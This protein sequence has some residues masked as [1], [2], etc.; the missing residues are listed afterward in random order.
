[1]HSNAHI[2]VHG[3]SL[4]ETP[5]EGSV[6]CEYLISSYFQSCMKRW[7]CNDPNK[8]VKKLTYILKVTMNSRAIVPFKQ[9]LVNRAS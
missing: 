8:A 5:C 7:Y 2:I 3:Y 9:Y 6:R 4:L 1:M